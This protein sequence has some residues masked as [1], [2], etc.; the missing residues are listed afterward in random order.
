MRRITLTTTTALVLMFAASAQAQDTTI[1]GGLT[2]NTPGAGAAVHIDVSG[3]APE[4]AGS[5]PES[6]ALGLQRGFKLDVRSVATRCTGSDQASG[7]CPAASRIGSGHAVVSTS[8]FL[9]QDIPATIDVFLGDPV[10]AGDLASA[11]VVFG[12]VGATRV[13]RTRLLVPATGPVGYEL[14]FDGIAAAVPTIP[15]VRFGLRSLSLDLGAQRKVTKITHKRVRVTRHGH[16]VTVRRK[17]KK[18]VTYN[19]LTN[20]KTCT[21]AWGVRLTVRVAGADRVRD[22]GV[23]C[24]PA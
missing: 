21:V 5:L 3:L 11:V 18:R 4:I 8:G 12:A 7:T 6:V 16:R 15:G 9:N 23:P 22:I 14:R 2:P 19:L 10:Q 24:A 17:V 13:A 20:P 1:S